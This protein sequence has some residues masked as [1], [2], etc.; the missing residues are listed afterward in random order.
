[1]TES[2]WDYPRPPRIEPVAAR[3]RVVFAG[4]TVADTT[5]GHRVLETSHP[6]VYVF[7]P[8]DVDMTLLTPVSGASFCEYKGRAQYFTL[9]AA[10][11]HSPRAAWCYPSPTRAYREIAGHL[12]FYASRID[13]AWVGEE[14]AEA[15]EGDFYGGW[16]TS[17]ISGPFKGPP[18]T[19]HW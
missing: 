13:E 7:P 6:P 17:G 18:G 5:R 11:H 1:M 9:D 3:L 14:R 12:A 8:V 10:G 2:V 15:Q 16:I 4:R 19:R